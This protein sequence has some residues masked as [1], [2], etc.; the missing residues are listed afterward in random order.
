MHNRIIRILIICSVCLLI[1]ACNTSQENANS[2]TQPISENDSIAFNAIPNLNTPRKGKSGYFLKDVEIQKFTIHSDRDTILIGENGVRLHIPANSFI[3]VGDAKPVQGIV[4]IQLQEYL[5]AGDMMLAGMSTRMTNGGILQTGGMVYITAQSEER[6]VMLNGQYPVKID[7]PATQNA[8]EKMRPFYGNRN[9]DGIVEWKLP[10]KTR[11]FR[12]INQDTAR[13][14]V[15]EYLPRCLHCFDIIQR[16]M[17]RDYAD[18]F[19][20]SESI[21]SIQLDIEPRG[22]ISYTNIPDSTSSELMNAILNALDS[23][24]PL[25]P[26]RIGNKDVQY[27]ANIKFQFK[28][29]KGSTTLKLSSSDITEYKK[30]ILR[31]MIQQSIYSVYILTPDQRIQRWNPT[32]HFG[33]RDYETKYKNDLFMQYGKLIA[34]HSDSLIFKSFK[35]QIPIANSKYNSLLIFD[36]GYINCDAFSSYPPSTLKNLIIPD[37]SKE[38]TGYLYFPNRKSVIPATNKSGAHQFTRIPNTEYLIYIFYAP[39]AIENHE[40]GLWVYGT[41]NIN[42]SNWEK[43]ILLQDTIT[44]EKL[45]E[46]I[47]KFK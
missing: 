38:S 33:N 35:N 4:N 10:D 23:I 6:S 5:N 24:Q 47:S 45:I 41:V 17:N 9:K 30:P 40:N 25:F 19:P 32:L 42:K 15:K 34:V 16:I 20:K 18:Y 44:F 27:S 37:K 22:I 28:A 31:E 46:N 21:I 8:N 29:H 3:H 11:N 2:A 43:P 26:A 12:K 1:F 14:V 13:L 36:L 39:L 7:F